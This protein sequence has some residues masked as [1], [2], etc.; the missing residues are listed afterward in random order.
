I[1]RVLGGGAV[2]GSVVLVGGEPGIGKST[3]LL[4]VAAF[5]GAR[6]VFV[7]GEESAAQV[8]RR[9]RRLGLAGSDLPILS[10]T[11][12][13]AIGAFLEEQRPA[14]CV[15][16]S[17]QTLQTKD[18]DGAP[19]GPAQ[20]RAAADRLV[21]VARQTGCVL[22]LVGQV[23]K[24]GGLAGPRTLEHAVDVVLLFE[25]D[26]HMAF[27]A[28]RGVKNRHGP[29]DEIGLFE[30]HESGLREVRNASH[31]LLEQRGDAGPGAVVGVA[32][33]GRRA[34]CVEVQSLLVGEKRAAP[35]RRGQGVDPRRLELL[36]GTIESLFEG[37]VQEREV[38]VNVVGGLSVRDPGIDLAIA[39]SVLGAQW[40]HAL[41]SDTTAIGEV[42]LRGEV[43]GV[44]QMTARLKEAR[45]MGFRRAFVP[46]GSPR[47]EGIRL[48][49]VRRLN[50]VFR[51][52]KPAAPET[53]PPPDGGRAP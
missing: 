50:E 38:F 22:V 25:G 10:S 11:D 9:A 35:R 20:V 16:D 26:R 36:I 23:T 41:P 40:G 7:A 44:A 27:R 53:W 24:V 42:G 34:L 31:L 29:T 52:T 15:I 32:V 19:G 3:L 37:A 33:E 47:L 48:T 43:R 17:I 30:M 8:A 12:T 49:E 18:V 28:L 45:A 4:G 1:D 6:G 5:A 46:R 2:P 39:A 51:D 14:L 21:P 13:V